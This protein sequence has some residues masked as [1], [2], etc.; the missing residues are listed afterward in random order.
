MFLIVSHQ[1][2]L[3]QADIADW[4]NLDISGTMANNSSISM[5]NADAKIRMRET[6][7]GIAVNVSCRF[8]ITSSETMNTSLAFVY[9]K[10]WRGYGGAEVTINFTIHVN[11]SR[12]NHTV[13]TWEELTSQGFRTDPEKFGGT[14]IESADFVLF[15]LEMQADATYLI[16]VETWA[17][18]L[19]T[20]HYGSFDYI[21]GS[22]TTFAGETHQTVEILVE[23]EIQFQD[24]S[25]F[26]DEYLVESTNESGSIANWDFIIDDMTN[27]SS[28]GVQ[29]TV[30]EY[31]PLPYP[32][33]T[34]IVILSIGVVVVFAFT[35]A[36]M[37]RRLHRG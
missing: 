22:A 24:T 36:L 34:Q 16:S 37:Y 13:I 33:P 2:T 23:E 28:V 8:E 20:N 25:F 12:V 30:S 27:I 5:P 4:V 32:R 14:W 31:N 26:P 7:Q 29:F 19:E 15:N 9:P 11:S 10:Y 17:Y 35:I 6:A 21:V 1:P 3:C 18:P